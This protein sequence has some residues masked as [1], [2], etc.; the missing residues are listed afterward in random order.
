MLANFANNRETKKESQSTSS[1]WENI[2][3]NTDF[4]S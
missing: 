2:N 4:H 3:F 1:R